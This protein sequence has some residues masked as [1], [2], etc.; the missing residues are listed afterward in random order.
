[1]RRTVALTAVTLLVLAAAA[2]AG[3]AA[4]PGAQ[5][6]PAEVGAAPS[7]EIS[8]RFVGRH[9]YRLASLVAYGYLSAVPGLEPA[10]LFTQPDAPSAAT[11]RLTY[12][13]EAR[14]APRPAGD[15]AF[16]IEGAG[17]LTIYVAE[18]GGASFAD[19]A[20]FA[21]GVPVATADIIFRDLVHL[22]AEGLTLAVGDGELTLTTTEAFQLGDDAYRLGHLG[23]RLRLRASGAAGLEEGPLAGATVQVAGTAVTLER[24]GTPVAAF[25]TGS[26]AAETPAAE[27]PVAE[28]PAAETPAAETCPG[29]GAW[30][31]A[32]SAR[33]ERTAEL[34]ATIP[35]D[36][37]VEAAD[38]DA[39]AA[40]AA[41]LAELAAAQRENVPEAAAAANGLFVAALLTYAPGAAAAATAAAAADAAAFAQALDR[42]ANGDDLI[43]RA[44]AETDEVAAAC[45]L[46]G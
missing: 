34:R 40:T 14:A 20:S 36:L 1:M 41:E 42:I 9:E 8:F 12:A 19:P 2:R 6:G 28:T 37:T 23:L 43:A 45:G 30:L 13:A 11:A 39:L 21:A 25:L 3:D 4:L 46:A 7:G 32:T 10:D 17:T 5:D 27:T 18:A 29:V 44:T 35:A 26:P 16:A 38:A 24:V 33:I 31:E 22:D 15:E